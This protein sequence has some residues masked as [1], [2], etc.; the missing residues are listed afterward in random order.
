MANMALAT[1][2]P[3]STDAEP[4]PHPADRPRGSPSAVVSRP[5]AARSLSS[6]PHGLTWIHLDP[7]IDPEIATSSRE[8]F[9]WHPLDVEDVL[10]KRQRP[11]VDDYADE[12][13]LFGDPPLPGLRQERPAAERRRARL[14]PR[15]GLPRHDLERRAAPGHAAVQPRA[16]GRAVPRAALR[17][18][19]GPAALRG[20]RRPLRLL[21][22][23]PRQDRVQARLDR[24][25]H[26][27]PPFRGDRHRHLEGEAGDH[28]LPQDHQAAAPC[29][30]P[31]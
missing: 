27:G 18:G 23:D 22:P 15:P 24:G 25:R 20:A 28:L 2:D 10:S 29:A 12:G 17:K 11:K 3:L 8:R 7:P 14:L 31:P 21:L 19:L 13:Y 6:A 5:R 4:A 16:G 26:R 1:D 30:A 9:G